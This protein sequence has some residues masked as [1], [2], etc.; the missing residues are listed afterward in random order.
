MLHNKSRFAL[1]WALAMVVSGCPGPNTSDAGDAQPDVTG[2]DARDVSVVD[3]FDVRDVPV[4]DVRDVPVLP[5]V[6]DVPVL[7]DAVDAVDVPVVVDIVDVP[8]DHGCTAG[9][10]FCGGSCISI[11]ND[12]ANCGGCGVACVT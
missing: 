8:P 3:A 6:V 7:V 2:S 12:P 4:V 9:M 10:A 5:D 1:V 11:T